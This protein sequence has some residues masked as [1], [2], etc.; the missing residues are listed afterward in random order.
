MRELNGVKE[1]LGAWM[2]ERDVTPVLLCVTGS[3]MWN[4]ARPDSDLDIRG[5]Y[6]THTYDFLGLHGKSDTLELRGGDA[7]GALD[8]QFYEMGKVF[9]MLLN[10][11]GNV[12][13][14]LLSPTVFYVNKEILSASA[15][16]VIAK[17]ALT[18]RLSNYYTGYYHSQRKRAGRNRGGKALVYAYRE[19]MA[20]TWL[21]RTGTI[22]Y[23][24]KQ[25]HKLYSDAYG[26]PKHLD[27]FLQ[28]D[29]Y[30]VPQSDAE[31]S[32]FEQDWLEMSEIMKTETSLSKL[33]E[34]IDTDGGTDFNQL[35]TDIRLQEL[36]F[37]ST[38]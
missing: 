4:L 10:H 12:V 26:L 5:I 11:N 8:G 2:R 1:E 30:T 9:N 14:M 22:I 35:L 28:P 33:P 38:T 32:I 37:V 31:L 18:K 25:L 16:R 17:Q 13:E 23:D 24:F 7:P 20:G 15:W 29:R 34:D 19:L 21:M 36:G 6:L 27:G 3:H